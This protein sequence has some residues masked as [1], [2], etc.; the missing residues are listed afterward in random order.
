MWMDERIYEFKPSSTKPVYSIDTPPPYINTPVHIGQAYTY[1]CMDAIAR[2]KRMAGF[3]V[4]FPIGLDRNGLP[5]EV[6]AEKEFKISIRNTPRE[7]F[8]ERARSLLDRY[9]G[10]SVSTFKKLGLSITGWEKAPQ[11]GAAYETDDPEYRR[12]TQETFINLYK[13]GLV[14]EGEKTANY[15][16][17]CRTTISDAE[18]EYKEYTASLNFIRFALVGGGDITIATTRP[19][20]LAA[21]K[22]VIFNPEDER[23]AHLAGRE[24]TVPIFGKTVKVV[25]HPYAKPEYGSGIVMICS[26][27]DY[28]DIRILRELSIP[29]HICD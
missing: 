1:T 22:L 4:L 7:E 14:Y 9:E 10:I 17:V 12:L 23:F 19:E 5:I 11:V 6:Q 18:V 13:T 3:N 24:A 15:C 29:P 28:N 16:P 8:I 27:G 25:P 21:C 26:Y 2:Y 20:L